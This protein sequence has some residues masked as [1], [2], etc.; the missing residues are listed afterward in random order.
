[1][2]VFISDINLIQPLERYAYARGSS[3]IVYN[4]TSLYSGFQGLTALT[5]NMYNVNTSGIPINVFIDT[6][7]FDIAYANRILTDDQMFDALMH[8]V[9]NSYQGYMVILLVYRD[10]YRDA[11]MESLIKFIQQRYGYN[12]WLIESIED[13]ECLKESYYTP[14]GIQYLDMDL[15]K[16]DELYLAGRVTQI[17]NYKL[18]VE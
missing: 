6:V 2:I 7:D 3:T 16:H 11:I 18:N 12:S 10:P 13:I 15:K 14:M 8:I 1:M 17:N 4:F 5:T 9:A